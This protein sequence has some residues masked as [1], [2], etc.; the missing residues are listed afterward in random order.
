MTNTTL[1]DLALLVARLGLG[2]V[3][4]A[5]GWQKWA[6]FGLTG[7]AGGFEK[8]GIPAPTAAAAFAA[9]VELV[10]GLAL[11]LGV[12]V[13]IAGLLLALDMAGAF[14]LVH[15]TKGPFVTEG[16]FE[17][18]VALGIGALLL[19]AFGAGRFSVDALVGRLRRSK[20]SDP[21]EVG[22]SAA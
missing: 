16:G 12:A 3:F 10:G 17:L 20:Q 21:Q 15:A 19:A 7:T 6:T 4:V 22:A 14:V 13:P 5:H 8:M 2:I 1:R 9:T 18:V 11:I